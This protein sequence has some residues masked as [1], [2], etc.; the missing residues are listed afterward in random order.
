MARK[1]SKVQIANLNEIHREKGAVLS[2][3]W[4]NGSGRY[5]TARAIPAHCEKL[6]IDEG[7]R[8]GGWVGKTC[9]RLKR[10]HPRAQYVIAIT[11]LRK[12]RKALRCLG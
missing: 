3:T 7:V 11:N 10:N 2:S 12:A 9:R 1:L 5:V 4:T 6:T 8:L